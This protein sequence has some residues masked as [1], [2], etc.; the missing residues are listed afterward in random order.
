MRR[1]SRSLAGAAFLLLAACSPGDAGDSTSTTEPGATTSSKQ[2]LAA[3]TTATTGLTTST[4]VALSTTTSSTTTT[5]EPDGNWAELPLVVT[6]FGALGW[7]D[8]SGWIDAEEAGQLPVLGGED[9]QIAVIGVDGTT[10]G[11][12]QTLVCEPLGNIGVE[13][14]DSDIL[15]EW[16]GPFGVAISAPWEI[17]PN[18]VEPFEDDGT[19]SA[20]AAG[21]LAERGLDV[22]NPVIKQLFRADLEGDGTNEILVV[23][24]ALAGGFLPEIG[25]YSLAFMQKVIEG[26]VVTAVIGESVITDLDGAFTVSYSIGTIADLSGDGRLEIVVNSAFFEGIGFELLEYIDDDLGLFPYLQIGCGS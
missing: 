12:P 10:T 17:T 11:G 13:L 21:L 7:W 2:P 23:A 22:A 5:T 3:S 24:E 25:D 20:I 16:P 18:L 15:G 4:T 26:E 14:E 8:G 9:Y 6:P 1:S 19:Y